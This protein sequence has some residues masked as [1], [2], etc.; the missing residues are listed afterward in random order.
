MVGGNYIPVALNT[1]QGQPALT[2]KATFAQVVSGGITNYSGNA[3]YVNLTGGLY[4][5]EADCLSL[6]SRLLKLNDTDC[7]TNLAECN[8]M[9][10][11]YDGHNSVLLSSFFSKDKSTTLGLTRVD[12]DDSENRITWSLKSYEE[13]DSFNIFCLDNNGF[14]ID[15]NVNFYNPVLISGQPILTGTASSLITQFNQQSSR[16]NEGELDTVSDSEGNIVQNPKKNASSTVEYVDTDGNGTPDSQ[17]LVDTTPVTAENIDSLV[18]PGGGLEITEVC[19]SETFDIVEC[20][21]NGFANPEV[22]YKT[23]K[24]SLATSAASSTIVIEIHDTEGVEYRNGISVG[25]DGKL[26]TKLKRLRDAFEYIRNDVA[27]ND[28]IINIYLQTDT[29][30]GE[31][32]NT[33][34]TFQSHNNAEINKGYIRIVGDQSKYQTGDLTKVK[35]KSKHEGVNAYVPMWFTGKTVSIFLVNLVFDLDDS[36]GVHSAIRTYKS[37]T[38][39]LV[40]CKISARGSVHALI[41]A[42]I[43]ARFEVHNYSDGPESDLLDPLGEGFWAPALELD[44]GPRAV[45]SS[46]GNGAPGDNFYC[47]YLFKADTGGVIRFPEYGLHIPFA[48]DPNTTFQSRIHFCSDKITIGQAVFGLESNCVVDIIALFTATNSLSFAAVNFPHF[49]RAL[50]FNSVLVRDGSH[51]VGTITTDPTTNMNYAEVINSLP[52]N[53]LAHPNNQ[54]GG[55]ATAGQDYIM[56]NNITPTLSLL[57]TYK[58][59]NASGN[60]TIGDITNYWDDVDWSTI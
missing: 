12:K 25:V 47:D 31:I 34:H 30:E 36:D 7:Y 20:E 8:S 11:H 26:T 39:T 19:Q 60:D 28:A 9:G 53:V 35:I 10:I 15:N 37:C 14:K 44:F 3:N 22:K 54:L 45:T 48:N 17:V 42:N 32:E 2:K 46:S 27:S 29:D 13:D 24:L 1:E 50:A 56:A 41:D 57:T 43:G 51:M 38:L 52:G 23:K 33:N 5:K 18:Q 4:A 16:E 21:T 49:L 58:G 59:R 40:G 6:S 55:I